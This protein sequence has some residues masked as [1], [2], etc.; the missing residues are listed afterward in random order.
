[1]KQKIKNWE[2]RGKKELKESWTDKTRKR[3]LYRAACI[4][5]LKYIFI[6]LIST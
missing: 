3:D 6:L 4:H 2:K 5:M 1:M